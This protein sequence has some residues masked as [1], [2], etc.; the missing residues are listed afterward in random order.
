MLSSNNLALYL[1]GRVG[2]E[3]TLRGL[4]APVLPLH[5]RPGNLVGKGGIEPPTLGVSSQ[6][7]ATELHPR[8]VNF[9]GD[10]RS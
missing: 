3:P 2:I 4:E 6:R 5:Q 9:G 1:A 7:S 10:D 8:C